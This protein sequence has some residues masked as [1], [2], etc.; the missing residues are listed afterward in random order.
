MSKLLAIMAA[1]L[2]MTSG[3]WAQQY[4]GR[5]LYDLSGDVKEVKSDSCLYLFRY[6]NKAKFDRNGR[7]KSA[8]M[9]YDVKGY[10]SGFQ[11][12]FSENNTTRLNITWTDDDCPE[13]LEM[14]DISKNGSFN[15][16]INYAYPVGS[17]RPDSMRVE[18]LL[19]EEKGDATEN[20]TCNIVCR[21]SQYEY[22]RQGNWISRRVTQTVEYGAKMP[23]NPLPAE[24][25]YIETR[26]IKYY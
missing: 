23:K 16:T 12:S 18:Y 4:H 6:K 15:L 3:A 20:Y 25:S 10:P 1:L 9:A 8:L 13:R 7:L 24:S 17:K 22:D 21:Y 14:T 2:F 5:A 11:I 26:K 19:K